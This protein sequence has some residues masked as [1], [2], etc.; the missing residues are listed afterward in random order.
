[1]DAMKLSLAQ[2]SFLIVAS[3]SKS[4][5]AVGPD[6]S[7][8]KPA[9][10]AVDVRLVGTGTSRQQADDPIDFVTADN[11]RDALLR[12]RSI[13][14]DAGAIRVAVQ[15]GV[16]TL[17]G[18]ARTEALKQ[19]VTVVTKA[20]GS[21]VRVDNQLVVNP[22]AVKAG[23]TMESTVDR[24]VSSRVRQAL[25]DDRTTAADASAVSILT[26]DGVVRVSG[27]VSSE[28]VK[29]HVGVVANAVGS[30]KR[31]DNRLGVKGR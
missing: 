26:K 13:A 10:P 28:T 20:V 17:Q 14:P 31:V 21:V 7:S 6:A 22:E 30:V 15:G 24:Q 25:L 2:L 16:A 23:G 27:M 11:V 1:M 18:F 9:N 4:G 8:A 19:R 3:C 29:T 5:A 12:E